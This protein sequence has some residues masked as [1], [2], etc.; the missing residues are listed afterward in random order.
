MANPKASMREM[1]PKSEKCTLNPHIHSKGGGRVEKGGDPCG[2]PAGIDSIPCPRPH[3]LILSLAV[4]LR[5]SIPSLAVALA[6]LF[7]SLSSP[8]P[9]KY[10]VSLPG[11]SMGTW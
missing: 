1:L 5:G 7:H 3:W 11:T 2:R 9:F 10:L 8:L 4:A 6:S